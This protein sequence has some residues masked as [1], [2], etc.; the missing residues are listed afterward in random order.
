MNAAPDTVAALRAELGLEGSLPERYLAWVGGMLTGDFGISYT[1]RTGGRA[2]RGAAW[3][4][5]RSRSMRCAVHAD[6]H[7]GGALAA[8]RRGRAADV[9]VMGTTQ[10]GI[11]VP[12]FWFAMLLVLVFAINLRWFSAGGFPGWEAGV[13]GWPEGADAA[14]HRAGAAAGVDPRARDALVR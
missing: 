9:A 8:A 4:S 13:W 2:C 6:R 3:V 10:L 12:N 14:G 5:C 1:Y 11:A 7:S